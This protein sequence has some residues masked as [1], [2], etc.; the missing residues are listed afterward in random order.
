[1]MPPDDPFEVTPEIQDILDAY[2]FDVDGVAQVYGGA[3]PDL[4]GGVV[5][6]SFLAAIEYLTD[7][8]E[9]LHFS[10]IYYDEDLD[11]YYVAIPDDSQ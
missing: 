5:F 1:M 7:E 9:L 11:V 8:V 3:D 6:E 10:R 4:R 2:A